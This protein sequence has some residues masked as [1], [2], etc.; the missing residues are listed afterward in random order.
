MTAL[1][2]LS[3]LLAPATA[4]A[5]KPFF[6]DNTLDKVIAEIKQRGGGWGA[7]VIPAD[8]KILAVQNF[9][10]DG[11]ISGFPHLYLLS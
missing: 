4:V 5:A 1:Q 3:L 9:W 8:K 6:A 10:S 7:E 2:R 11:L